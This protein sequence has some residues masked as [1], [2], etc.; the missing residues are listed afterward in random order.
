VAATHLFSAKWADLRE[1]G[2]VS[3]FEGYFAMVNP[4]MAKASQ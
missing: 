2:W 3:L 4:A 1:E